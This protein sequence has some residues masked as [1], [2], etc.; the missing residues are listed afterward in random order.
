MSVLRRLLKPGV[1]ASWLEEAHAAVQ[2]RLSLAV[3]DGQEVLAIC[4]PERDLAHRPADKL[5]VFDIGAGEATRQGRLLL[6]P[7]P[8]ADQALCQ[9]LGRLL[10]RS[11]REVVERGL[12]HRAANAETLEQYREAAL[13]RRA[14][15][16]LNQSLRMPE[17]AQALLTECA[18]G[19]AGAELGM[20]FSFDDEHQRYEPLGS[21]GPAKESALHSIA[22]SALF[23][24]VMRGTRG[25]IVN[26]LAAD[27]RWQGEVPG[28]AS[29]LCLPLKSPGHWAG[30]L[31][32][33]SSRRLGF[34]RAA[35]L[36]RMTTIAS[37]AATAMANAHH[38]EQVQRMLQALL[39]ALATAI[40]SR[41][42][43]TSGHSQRVAVYAS[44]LAGAAA[45]TSLLPAAP[46]MAAAG[47]SAIYFAGLLH[48]V[49][50]IGVREEVLTKSTRLG[51]DQ[52][53]AMRL[54]MAVWGSLTGHDWRTDLDRL[55]GI[56]RANFLSAEDAEFICS[57]ADQKVMIC[58]EEHPIL[59]PEERERLLIPRGNLTREEREEISRH[60]AESH[61][62]L[63][64]IPFPPQY[65]QVP[66]IVRQHHEKLDGSG[67]PEGAMDQEI[68]PSSRILA[69][70][71]I[72]D[73]LTAED[74]PYKKALPREKAL[75]ILR[76]EAG[77][78]K[79]DQ[80]LVALFCERID[81][82]ET[83]VRQKEARA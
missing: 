9:G 12:A 59:G 35:D 47:P 7:G 43:C 66:T 20:V 16:T 15:N 54:R 42:P 81:Q 49:G 55:E 61:R 27:P 67:Y 46:D 25:E 37:V 22:E 21:F 19:A 72:Y 51:R 62:I 60:P 6:L 10:S 80:G 2:G 36:M 24:E 3:L 4:G 38:F 5:M 11:L 14:A 79:L 23:R 58:D 26:D 63:W 52:V 57:L 31:V 64:H 33:G 1:L 75:A 18:G 70:V 48:D 83:L 78:G 76:E 74:R 68:L 53:E 65:R 30:G 69:I 50:K 8:G 32:L 82:I 71:D 77:Q 56:N 34:F 29:L 28:L 41:D 17:V 73:A 45:E 39:R 44:A 13:L 40:D